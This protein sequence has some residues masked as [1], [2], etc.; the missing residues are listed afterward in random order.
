MY[1]EMVQH[2]Q[3]PRQTQVIDLKEKSYTHHYRIQRAALPL[4]A[5]SGYA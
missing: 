5:P 2:R 4:R 1:V 3:A